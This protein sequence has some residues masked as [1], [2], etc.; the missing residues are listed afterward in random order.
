MW[1]AH[2]VSVRNF[3][4]ALWQL[5]EEFIQSE[6]QKYGGATLTLEMIQSIHSQP[7]E[8]VS[9]QELA[10]QATVLRLLGPQVAQ[11]VKTGGRL[12]VFD[13]CSIM[14]EKKDAEAVPHS[15]ANSS[16]SSSSSQAQQQEQ[17]ESKAAA[18]PGGDDEKKDE[19]VELDS[20]YLQEVLA[21]AKRTTTQRLASH[22]NSLK[23]FNECFVCMEEVAGASP[24]QCGHTLCGPCLHSFCQVLIHLAHAYIYIYT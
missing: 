23:S 21:K 10:S 3:V 16:S 20:S 19:A 6:A 1:E 15:E 14:E 5:T 24:L 11:I 18:S 2:L 13:V 17:K 7:T 8:Y 22:L 12:T 9:T 4:A